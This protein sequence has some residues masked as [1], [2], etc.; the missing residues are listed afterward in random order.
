MQDISSLNFNILPESE[1][2][3]HPRLSWA[4]ELSF[5]VTVRGLYRVERM[6]KPG[7]RPGTL[8]VSNHQRESDVPIVCSA[9]VRRRGLRIL[10]PLPFFAMREDLLH[11]DALFNLLA[12]WP[13]PIA[14][15][16]GKI[17]LGWLFRGVRTM[18][19]RRVREFR[20]GDTVEALVAA[21]LGDEPPQAVFNPRGQREVIARMQDLPAHVRDITRDAM[22]QG[23]RT[24]WGLRR[25]RLS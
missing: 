19:M 6:L 2:Y 15:A 18:P 21:G 16:L 3:P 1:T 13:R 12:K 4:I 24:Y 7:C 5:D 9:L 22:G 23:W 14:K 10:D 8:V 17:P 20:L 11:R 25:L